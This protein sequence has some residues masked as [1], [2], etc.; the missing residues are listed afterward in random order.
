MKKFLIICLLFLTSFAKGQVFPQGFLRATLPS[1]PIVPSVTSLTGKIWMD[2]N[3]GASRVATSSTDADAYRDLYQWG[4]GTDGHQLRTSG[5]TS[6]LSSTDVPGHTMF[7]TINS[8][9]YDW[10]SPQ[11]T[12]LWQGISGANNP[13]PSGFRI[14]TDTELDAERASWS[15]SNSAG[16]FASVLKLPVAGYR[17]DSD[18]SLGNVGTYGSYWSSTVDGSYSRYLTFY[19]SD[20]NMFFYYRVSGFSVRC[21]QD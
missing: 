9:L 20:A 14:P 11:N 1:V 13:C 16:A 15:S 3:L 8:G 12:N 19:S 6:T 2:R 17:Y 4:R 7:I 18:G 5:T 21:I 10:R